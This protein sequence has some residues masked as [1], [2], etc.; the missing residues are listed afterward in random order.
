MMRI[1]LRLL[2]AV[3]LIGAGWTIGRAQ[4]PMHDFEIVIDA[5]EG[6][7]RVECVKGCKLAWI[8]RMVPGTVTPE[9]TDFSY[10]CSNSP[11][12]RCGSGRIGGWIV[13]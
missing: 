5:P 3:I 7:T 6:Q 2:L 12:Q 4:A 10:R 13:R 11:T 9:R 1:A 8:E